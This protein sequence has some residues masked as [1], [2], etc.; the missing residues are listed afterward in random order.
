MGKSPLPA[1][2]PGESADLPI[3]C[4]PAFPEGAEGLA[5]WVQIRLPSTLPPQSETYHCLSFDVEQE[6]YNHLIKDMT[7]NE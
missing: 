1:L 5:I 4:G 6:A 7:Q 2:S 3:P